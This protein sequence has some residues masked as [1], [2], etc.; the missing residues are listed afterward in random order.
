MMVLLDIFFGRFKCGKFDEDQEVQ[1]SIAYLSYVES[2]IKRSR[3]MLMAKC[4]LSLH[5]HIIFRWPCSHF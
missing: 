4:C 1:K 5:I 3:Q 2:L